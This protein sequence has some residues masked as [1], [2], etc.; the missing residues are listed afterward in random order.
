MEEAAEQKFS[1][2]VKEEVMEEVNHDDGEEYGRVVLFLKLLGK[3]MFQW[4]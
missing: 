3:S 2:C 4:L 1:K